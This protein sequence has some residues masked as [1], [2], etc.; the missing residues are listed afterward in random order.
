MTT[1]K[2]A[3]NDQRLFA[4]NKV[5]LASG[6]INS[7]QMEV[8]F[9]DAW[10]D[11]PVRFAHFAVQ[12]A[13]RLILS[14]ETDAIPDVL[15]IDNKA[16]VPAT[17]LA[18]SGVLYVG[19]YGDNLDG[20]ARKTSI[21]EVKFIIHKGASGAKTTIAPE[22]DAFMQYLAAMDAKIDPL[23][24]AA[25]EQ[26]QNTMAAQYKTFTDKVAADL[27]K[28]K[29]QYVSGTVLWTYPAEVLPAPSH[30]SIDLSQYEK[31]TVIVGSY[32]TSELRKGNRYCFR[33]FH[34]SYLYDQYVTFT[35]DEIIFNG[36]LDSE[37]GNGSNNIWSNGA[38]ITIIGYKN[39]AIIDVPD[40]EFE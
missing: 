32:V 1:I 38:P 6:D 2:L 5:T 8:E 9:C 13:N 20:T 35:D 25:V 26:M 4:L 29:N 15:M 3:L 33:D 12:T 19:V 37:I 31:F 11:Y 22:T 21:G 17:A 24:N 39:P 16:I 34:E 28:F 23:M 10:A 30:I 36:E 7:V 14:S 27:E 40:F 18:E